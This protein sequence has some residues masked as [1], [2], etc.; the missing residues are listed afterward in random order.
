VRSV[1]F[2]DDSRRQA[3][4]D[5]STPVENVV[6]RHTGANP[7]R[8]GESQSSDGSEVLS[9][10]ST[11]VLGISSYSH[12]DAVGIGKDTVSLRSGIGVEGK[13]TASNRETHS[14]NFESRR[15]GALSNAGGVSN[16]WEED[17]SNDL[18]FINGGLGAIPSSIG[19][20]GVIQEEALREVAKDQ[21]ISEDLKKEEVDIRKI[22]DEIAA[23]NQFQKE[24]K[25]RGEI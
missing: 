8:D 4:R 14:G 7:C 5:D 16:S 10:G 25:E 17:G 6:G 11:K 18:S 12:E 23:R 9:E 13:S 15:T 2:Y 22:V 20:G 21:G 19:T 24:S 3:E 1:S